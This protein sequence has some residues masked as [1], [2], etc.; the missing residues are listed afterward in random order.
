MRLILANPHTH[1]FGKLVSGELFRRKSSLKYSYFLTEY[2][3]RPDQLA[4]YCD[5]TRS[6]FGFLPP[7][8]PIVFATI[9]LYV[10]MIINGLNPFRF[11]AYWNVEKL[12][13]DTDILLDFSKSLV[14][15]SE[16]KIKNAIWSQ[17]KGIVCIHFT[18][19]FKDIR[20]LSKNFKLIKNYVI[21]A[22]NDLT[23]NGFFKKYFPSVEFV[24]HLP[25]AYSNRFFYKKEYKDRTAK[26]LALGSIV[27][28]KNSD[29][30]AYF[31]DQEGLHPMRK[32]LHLEANSYKKEID[33]LILGCEDPD[34]SRKIN[35]GD[36]LITKFFKRN[37]PYF[38]I[39]KIYPPL[40]IQYFKFDIVDK[41]NDYKMFI[42]PEESV[43]LPSVNVFDGMTCKSAYVGIEDSMYTNI[44]LI[45]GVHYIAY[46]KD[47]LEDLI[48]K[49][50]YYQ[51]HPEELE[52]IA[53]NGYDFVRKNFNHENI[54]KLFWKDLE[55]ISEKFSEYG[56]VI[57]VCSFKK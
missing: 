4:F 10:W 21:I 47:D 2:R 5:G 27:R 41:F 51:G 43:G 26:C 1:H 49:I 6:S 52:R 23:F 33:S 37:F 12:D 36:S 22:E 46:K 31:G 55:R 14:D 16:K 35:H 15:I 32:T 11:R 20:R 38:I 9:E 24:Y 42:S 57:S 7:L 29:F 8:F 13:P 18:H 17:Y 44:G 30:L 53:E 25:F 19:Y 56:K 3:N 40:Q 50:R 48:S 45:S 54:A 39:E 34:V 28:V